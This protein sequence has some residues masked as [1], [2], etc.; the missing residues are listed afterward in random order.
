M[1]RGGLSLSSGHPV[2]HEVVRLIAKY[3]QGASKNQNTRSNRQDICPRSR[4]TSFRF[5]QS[6]S[7]L[8]TQLVS[9]LD[10]VVLVAHIVHYHTVLDADHTTLFSASHETHGVP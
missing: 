3:P 4:G 8:P 2:C 7:D 1:L 5:K 9:H 6:P 10:F